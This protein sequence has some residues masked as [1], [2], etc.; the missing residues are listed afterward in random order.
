LLI[1][2]HSYIVR[3]DGISGNSDTAEEPTGGHESDVDGC[4]NVGNGSRAIEAEALGEIG[5]R[6]ALCDRS[7]HKGLPK[8][9]HME[10]NGK[11]ATRNSEM[12]VGG[13]SVNEIAGANEDIPEHGRPPL[14]AI[15][16]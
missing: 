15:F 11:C 13:V 7:A 9:K 12:V 5:E 4:G 2:C 16:L 14:D 8:S 1:T 10:Q 6:E 3:D